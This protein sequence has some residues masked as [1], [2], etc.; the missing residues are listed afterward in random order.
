MSKLSKNIGFCGAS[1]LVAFDVFWIFG[2][3]KLRGAELFNQ[4]FDNMI[5]CGLLLGI[6]AFCAL[7]EKPIAIKLGIGSTVIFGLSAISRFIS[8]VFYSSDLMSFMNET[9]SS[10]KEII[11]YYGLDF[12]KFFAFIPLIISAIFLVVHVVKDKVKKTT[13]VLGGISIIALIGVWAIKLYELVSTG[14]SSQL[15]MVEIYLNVFKA[16]LIWDILLVAGYAFVIGSLTG[17]MDKKE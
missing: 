15:S 11:S 4:I 12:F 13:Q 14:M 10:L 16:G 8:V 2:C 17:A 1:I 5:P 6:F 3:F 9:N 7:C